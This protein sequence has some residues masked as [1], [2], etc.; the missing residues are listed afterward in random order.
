MPLP[1]V[2]IIGTYPGC[3]ATTITHLWG[4]SADER[5]L[6]SPL[7]AK[8]SP[9]VVPVLMGA[10]QPMQQGFSNVQYLSTVP[11]LRLGGIL[12][13]ACTDGIPLDLHENISYLR[14]LFPDIP[15]QIV[16][17]QD[18]LPDK[19][20]N[21]LP[22]WDFLRPTL[23]RFGH[24]RLATTFNQFASIVD[25]IVQTERTTPTSSSNS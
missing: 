11:H 18:D 13:R 21:E 23:K 12:I 19:G 16:D 17:Y 15:I 8:G 3:G 5:P 2:H 4:E 24:D 9:W 7:P 1:L 14:G 6:D 25:Y 10:Y 22:S 20:L